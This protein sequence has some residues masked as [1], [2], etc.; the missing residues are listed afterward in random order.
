MQRYCKIASVS[1]VGSVFLTVFVLFLMQINKLCALTAIK[2]ALCLD[3][4]AICLN[5]ASAAAE[6][7]PTHGHRHAGAVVVAAYIT[8]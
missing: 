8:R 4:C 1:I 3:K 2:T 5:F 7:L 6:G